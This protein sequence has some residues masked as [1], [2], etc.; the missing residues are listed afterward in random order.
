VTKSIRNQFEYTRVFLKASGIGID[1]YEYY[2]RDWWWNHTVQDNLRLSKSGI[3]FVEKHAKIKTYQIE[4]AN[5]LLGRTFIQ[6]S[7]LFT[8]PY[9]VKKSKQIVVLG[10]EETV[11]LSLHAN[12]LQQY[13]DNLEV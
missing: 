6:L 11:L 1:N 3:T 7:R 4:L 8:C 5:P 10:E 13:L 12:N 9:Y 2:R